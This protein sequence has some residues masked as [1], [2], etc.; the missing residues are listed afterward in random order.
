MGTHI[1]KVKSTAMDSWTKEQYQNML[2]WGNLRVNSHYMP[3]PERIEKPDT[4]SDIEME[5][6]IRDKY[7]RQ[8]FRDFSKTS[9]FTVCFYNCFSR[10]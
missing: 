6:Y 2:D 4:Q 3:H 10:R 7:E 8:A 9:Q 1:S 5:L